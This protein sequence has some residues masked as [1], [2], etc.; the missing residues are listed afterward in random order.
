[1]A[2]SDLCTVTAVVSGSIDKAKRVASDVVTVEASMTYDEF[3]DGDA[4]ESHDVVY[5]ATPNSYH[6]EY[7]EAAARHGKDALLRE[8]DG[9]DR[10]GRGSDGRRL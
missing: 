9:G 6:R 7:V 1:M 4:T 3:V 2:D 10:R 5:I 8:T